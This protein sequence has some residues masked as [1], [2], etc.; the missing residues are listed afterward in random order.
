V[1]RARLTA[2]ALTAA[3]LAAAVAVWQALPMLIAAAGL[4]RYDLLVRV[5]L[6]FA[7]LSIAERLVARIAALR[8][9]KDTPDDP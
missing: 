9:N 4:Q 6:I 2:A 5:L 1:S 8:Q 3:T 7:A